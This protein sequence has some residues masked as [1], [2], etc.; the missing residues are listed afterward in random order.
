MDFESGGNRRSLTAIL[1][2]LASVLLITAG[3][4]MRPV[5]DRT[6][7]TAASVARESRPIE[8]FRVGDRVITATTGSTSLP[9]RVDVSTWR[10][11]RLRGEST[12][13]DGTTDVIDVET[14]QPPEWIAE[15]D[16]HVGAEVPLPLDLQEMGL[17]E[18]LRSIVIANEPCPSIEA[19]AGRVVLTTVNHFNRD[20]QEL[21]VRDQSG[22]TQTLR[23]TGLHKFFSRSRGQW[24]EAA[25]LTEG[26][27]LEGVAGPITVV[28]ISPLGGA[29]RVYNMTVEDDHV[30]RVSTLGILVH[31]NC[32]QPT[33]PTPGGP[34]G[35]GPPATGGTPPNPAGG[36]P[37]APTPGV[38]ATT[39]TPP[40][41]GGGGYFPGVPGSGPTATPP[42]YPPSIAPPVNP[43]KPTP[44]FQPPT[45]PP[46]Y[47]PTTIPPGWTLRLMPPTQQYP[48]GYWVLSKPT[49]GGHYQPINP[50]T[51][52]PGTKPQT[53][54]PMPHPVTF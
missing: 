38:G 8:S 24:I 48:N 11:L 52:K 18:S 5:S 6:L 34:T 27:L 35:G 4:W 20:V 15:Y 2:S 10:R 47:P 43:P 13:D 9:T 30:Y 39:P 21:V 33:G 12:W 53:H 44:N 32:S 29:Q 1:A 50:A 23:P 28:G 45:N 36:T 19:G 46:Q 31:N 40:S 51:G 49:G 17:P 37:A 22:R 41:A 7:A 14:L 26:E 25:R 3:V 54:V 42:A 16:A